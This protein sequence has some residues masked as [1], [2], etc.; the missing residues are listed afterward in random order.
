[1]PE[2]ERIREAVLFA[3]RSGCQL[4]PDGLRALGELPEGL[5]PLEVVKE[6]V[7]RALEAGR[8]FIGREEIEE[9]AGL[10]R[11]E[12]EEKAPEALG[13]GKGIGRALAEEIEAEVEV[14]MDPTS[15]SGSEGT[16]KDFLE[17]FRDRCKRLSALL[18][19][20]LDARDA[21][22]I[23]EALRARLN[24]DVKMIGMV[25]EK[26]EGDGKVIAVLED[27]GAVATVV[28]TPKAGREAYERARRLMPDQV[29]CVRAVRM[30]KDLFVA[31]ELIM[32][33]LPERK[34]AVKALEEPICAVLISDLHFGSKSFMSDAFK[35]FISWLRGE[36]GNRSLRQLA[37]SVKYVVIAGDLVDGVGVYPG[38]ERELELTDIYAQYEGLA[39]L[40]SELPEHIRLVVSP[41]NH[42]AC[43]RA[44]PQPAIPKEY[45]GPLY[46]DDRILMLGNPCLVALHGVK[47]LIYHGNSFDDM[48]S[49]VP[50]LSVNQP[51]E[52]MRLL[53]EARH[54]A[55]I[56]GLKTPIAP[57]ARDLLVIERVPDIFHTGHIHVNACGTYRGVLL[58]N[59]GAWQTQTEYQRAR[60]IEPTPGKAVVVRL[61]DLSTIE[62][63]FTR[64]DLWS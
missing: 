38:Q 6:V 10:G 5:D 60:G 12:A 28:F 31:K 42:D 57:T 53:L 30:A 16:L 7:R 50:G 55:P 27:D 48:V 4:K 45:A 58:V 2:Q 41:G 63:D 36:L 29:V 11:E 62:L 8:D 15:D 34:R 19:R 40:L 3:I 25:R 44:L 47:L 17:Y 61:S 56:Y 9:A 39:A 52:L 23:S 1:M 35:R 20:R 22:S 49:A 37:G 33:S 13:L 32:P 59:S 24:E 54:L 21:V 26:R 64:P 46:D 18:R 43:R 14:L 51:L